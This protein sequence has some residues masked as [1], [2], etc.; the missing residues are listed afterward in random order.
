MVCARIVAED[1]DEVGTLH[2]FQSRGTLAY[3]ERLYQR[4]SG[5]FMAHVGT[6]GKVVGAEL[7]RKQLQKKGRLIGRL[8]RGVEG[9]LIGRIETVQLVRDHF[10]GIRPRDRL[11]VGRVGVPHHGRR[12]TALRVKPVVRLRGQI[13]DGMLGEELRSDAL[14][15]RLV[16]DCLGAILAKLEDLPLLIRAGPRAALTIKPVHVVNLQKS[17][18]RSYRTHLPDAIKRCV[19]DRLECRQRLRRRSRP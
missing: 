5:R 14:F 9:G 8:A 19:P 16:R 11:I 17:F 12:Q 4:H 18:G 2:V 7:A 3:A 13:L 6:I 10:E 15:R 1:K